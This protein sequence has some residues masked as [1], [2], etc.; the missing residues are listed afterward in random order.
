MIG[1]SGEKKTLRL[2]ARYA[3]ACNLF[4]SP[5]I[6][7][8]AIKEKLDVLAHHCADEGNDD[9]GIRKTILWVGPLDPAAPADFID[10]M[11]AYADIGIVQVHVMPMQDPVDFIH[12]LGASIIPAVSA[13]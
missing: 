9:A 4:A 1:G 8:H 11:K 3:D 6:G 12:G 2:V 7:P 5:E 10:R 13:L